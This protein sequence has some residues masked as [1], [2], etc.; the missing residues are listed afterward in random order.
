MAVANTPAYYDVATIK[1]II[2]FIVEAL[3]KPL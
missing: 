3:E 2:S 1:A